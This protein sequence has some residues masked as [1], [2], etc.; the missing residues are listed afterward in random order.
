M[1]KG[2]LQFI[3]ESKYDSFAESVADSIMQVITSTN[4]EKGSVRNVKKVKEFSKPLIFS[5]ILSIVRSPVFEPEKRK[6]FKEVPW[7]KDN[8]KKYGFALDANSYISNN[9]DFSNDPEVE[10]NMVINP[11]TEPTCYSE[12][13]FKLLD[14]VRH[15]VEHLLQK[16]DNSIPSHSGH[17]VKREKYLSSYKYFLLP[18]EMPAMVSGMRLSALKKGNPIDLEFENYLLPIKNS[19]LIS[20]DEVKAVIKEWLKF[21]IRHFPET[22]ISTKYKIQ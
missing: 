8:F 21:T 22:K 16:G 13:Y 12:L 19:G 3:Y 18:D 11:K 9:D 6:N 10:I 7:E 14:C 17:S 1:I 4:S 15:E 5:L 2:F 20:E